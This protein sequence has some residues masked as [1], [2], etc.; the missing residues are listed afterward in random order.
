[1]TELTFEEFCQ[2]PLLY[3]TGISFE[4]GAQRLYR[5]DDHGIQKEVFTTRSPLTLQWGEGK[6]Y[7]FVDGDPRQ[8]ETVADC[9]VAYMEKVCGVTH[10]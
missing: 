9:Y 6:A 3:Y 7:Y 10:D 2:L 8:F 4:R 1:M 5:N